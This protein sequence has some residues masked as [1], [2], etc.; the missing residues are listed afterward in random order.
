M[1][2]SDF[3]FDYVHLLNYYKCHKI[4]FHRGG[5]HLDFSNW[6]KNKKATTN[7]VN[8]DD[9]WFQ[10]AAKVALNHEEPGKNSQRTS[11]DKSFINKYNW[12]GINYPPRKDDCKRFEKNNPS[13]VL[14]VL[15]VKNEYISCIHFKTH[16]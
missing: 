11:K 5:S 16:L 13:M 12:K 3:I 7:P 9:K 4:N 8:D 10:Y 2:S 1:R 15:Y 6:I 14:D